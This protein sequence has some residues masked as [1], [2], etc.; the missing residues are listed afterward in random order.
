MKKIFLV[1]IL[2]FLAAAVPVAF[3]SCGSS[4]S[5][6]G[7]GFTENN[8]L[9]GSVALYVTDDLG[10]YK[11]V[12]IT[13]NDIQLVH[14][15][16]GASCDV[17]E[18]PV[19][20]DLTELSTVF[21]LLDVTSCPSRNYNRV[22][23]DMD[24]QT[25][26]TDSGGVSDECEMNTYKSDQGSTNALI[27]DPDCSIN[28][29]GA[30]NVLASETSNVALDFDLKEFEV[31]QFG[32]A[33]CT[34]T[35]KV[36]PVNSSDFD[37]RHEEGSK[38]GISGVI[39]NLDTVN[40]SFTLTAESGTFAVT[41]TDVSAEGIDSLLSRAQTDGLT[42]RVECPVIDLTAQTI[43]ASVIYVK[44][45]GTVSSLN[46]TDRTFTLT[47]QTIKTMSVSYTA[48]GVEGSLS[49]DSQVEV[50]LNGFVDSRYVA[51]EVEVQ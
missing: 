33:F 14:I 41:Y 21:Q 23:I 18:N 3:L 51:M 42:V 2:I 22:I 36:F 15:A 35:M 1:F 40:K 31:S 8:S 6:S 29:S 24:K 11:K 32:G 4:G 10:S 7:G 45:E 38:E 50:K 5:G 46:A 48:D 30:V 39:S 28:M 27:C 34:V 16:T 13:I 9:P 26:L 43:A 12:S 37:K 49:N 25:I 19:T 47:Y 20:V 17:L 44:A